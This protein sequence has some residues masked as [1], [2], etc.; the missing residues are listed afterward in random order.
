MAE[1]QRPNDTAAWQALA[2][3]YQQIKDAHLRK[4][5]A[6]DPGRGERFVVYSGEERIRPA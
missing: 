1:S 4:L 6:D 3:H 5:F 2:T